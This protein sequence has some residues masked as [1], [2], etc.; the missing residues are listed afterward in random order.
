MVSTLCLT[1]FSQQLLPAPPANDPCD[2]RSD[3][4]IFL[5]SVNHEGRSGKHPLDNRPFGGVSNDDQEHVAEQLKDRR[6]H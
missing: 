6:F 3:V 2:P 4:W 1:P 5:I